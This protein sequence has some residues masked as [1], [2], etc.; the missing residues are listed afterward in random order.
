MYFAVLAANNGRSHSHNDTG[1][2]I[3]YQDCQPVA[4]DVGVE[5]YTAKTF[6]PDRY[7]I[8]TMQSAYHNLPTIGGVM[9]HDG[10]KFK[11]TDRK[12]ASDDKRAT[13]SFDIASAYPSEA[14][15]KSWIRTVTLDRKLNQVMISE[16]FDLERAVPVSFSVMTPRTATTNDRIVTMKLAEGAGTVCLLTFDATQLAPKIELIPLTDAGLR[17]SWG[18]QINRILLNSRNSVQSGTL[19]YTFASAK[20][21]IAE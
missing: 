19:A 13:Y 12:Y 11:A 3:I 17:E 21:S 10:V 7:T 14:G 6:S 18:N 2:Y 20:G 16:E 4:I 5:A 9:Q 1:S 8:W 15:V